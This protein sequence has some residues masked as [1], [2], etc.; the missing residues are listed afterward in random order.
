MQPTGFKHHTFDY[1]PRLP[2]E[3][4]DNIWRECLPCRVVEIDTHNACYALKVSFD[5]DDEDC[6][7]Q[8]RPPTECF[9]ENTSKLNTAAPIISRVC[10]EARRVAFETGGFMVTP[11]LTQSSSQD[12]LKKSRI[13]FDKERDVVHFHWTALVDYAMGGR[14]EPGHLVLV[15]SHLAAARV[16]CSINKSLLSPSGHGTPWLQDR[17]VL[18]RIGR[19]AVCFETV[20]IHAREG[21][22]VASGL[23]G[24]LG[25]ER[26]ILVDA[27]DYQRL[28]KLWAFW[29]AHREEHP[30]PLTYDFFSECHAQHVG[31]EA[32]R[33]RTQ[34]IH[35]AM[36]KIQ[37]QWVL[38]K[39]DEQD[40][41]PGWSER[42]KVWLA[43]PDW[44]PTRDYTKKQRQRN[45]LDYMA[46]WVPN[47]D[48]PW[49]MQVYSSMPEFRPVI[50]FRLCTDT[51]YLHQGTTRNNYLGHWDDHWRIKCV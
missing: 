14:P 21:P 17:A 18:E 37:K 24:L 13:W 20:C 34:V 25:E 23:F 11:F 41:L 4:R 31:S 44:V 1:F 3:L 46:Q 40:E 29:D 49:I 42:E 12:N 22:A 43:T 28:G 26:I 47:R 32:Q 2:Q 5:D 10:R 45:R 16:G 50:M 36:E 39:W 19:F 6:D 35:D 33:R 8:A 15:E 30:D 51:Y 48:H 9:M 27:L 38:D 7:H